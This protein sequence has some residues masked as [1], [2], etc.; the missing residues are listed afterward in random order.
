MFTPIVNRR[1]RDPRPVLSMRKTVSNCSV[2]NGLGN[3]G[4]GGRRSLPVIWQRSLPA[5]A[6]VPDVPT[7]TDYDH[8][9]VCMIL[10][11]ERQDNNAAWDDWVGTYGRQYGSAPDPRGASMRRL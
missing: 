8:E 4:G 9:T 7:E 2:R 3:Q 11:Y 1:L 5:E 6:G 10:D